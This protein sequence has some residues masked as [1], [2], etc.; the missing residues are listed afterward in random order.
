MGKLINR[1]EL[2]NDADW[3]FSDAFWDSYTSPSRYKY[4]WPSD[5]FPIVITIHDEIL[6]SK[7][8]PTIRKWIE[9]NVLGTVIYETIDKSYRHYWEG[10]NNWDHSYAVINIWWAFYFQDEESATLF[11]LRFGDII[12]P[13]TD[14]HPTK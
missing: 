14:K 11:K 4:K 6:D 9:I 3:Y 13:I 10:N 12:Q 2:C 5:D 8:K 1:D 7:L